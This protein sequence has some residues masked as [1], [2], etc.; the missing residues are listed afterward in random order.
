MRT[1]ANEK[2]NRPGSVAVVARPPGTALCWFVVRWRAASA[3]WHGIDPNR[4]G[5]PL[6]HLPCQT[7]RVGGAVKP[8]GG[9]NLIPVLRVQGEGFKDVCRFRSVVEALLIR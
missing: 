8:V 2:D 9:Q 5:G 6:G 1:E 4:T 7:A 3:W